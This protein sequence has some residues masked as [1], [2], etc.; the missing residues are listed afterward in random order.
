MLDF[1]DICPQIAE[2]LSNPGAGEDSAQIQNPEMT[3]AGSTVRR[4]TAGSTGCIAHS[5]LIPRDLMMG[6]HS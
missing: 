5:R 3:Q 2:K 4:T 6:P 1:Y